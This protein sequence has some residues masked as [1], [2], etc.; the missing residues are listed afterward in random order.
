LEPPGNPARFSIPGSTSTSP[1]L[2]L[3]AQRGRRL[4]RQAD[5]AAPQARSSRASSIYRPPST[6]SS[7]RPMKILSP[8]PGPPIPMPS[9]KRS[10]AGR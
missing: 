10:G 5:P 6:A 9:S 4:L 7:P 3:L 1:D 8:S 2:G